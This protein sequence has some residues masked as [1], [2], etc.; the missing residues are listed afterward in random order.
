MHKIA[1]LKELFPS[2]LVSLD[3]VKPFMKWYENHQIHSSWDMERYE[4]CIAAVKLG[5]LPQVVEA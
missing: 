4:F 2:F 5:C 1:E 3:L